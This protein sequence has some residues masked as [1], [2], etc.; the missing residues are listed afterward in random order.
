MY[1]KL[2]SRGWKAGREKSNPLL[3]FLWALVSVSLIQG[4]EVVLS[5]LE[6]LYQ[7]PG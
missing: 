6:W 3:V 7:P 1:W 4:G 2:S 5:A